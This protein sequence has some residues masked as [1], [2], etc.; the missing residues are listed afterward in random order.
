MQG[1]KDLSNILRKGIEEFT[2][3]AAVEEVGVVV[4]STDGII[5]IKG[6]SQAMAGEIIEFPNN[7]T[8]MVFNLEREDILTVLFGPHTVVREGDLARC[9][10]RVMQVPVGDALIGR[11]VD[12]IGTPIINQKGK[13]VYCIYCAIG[14]KL[15]SVVAV[16]DI[17]EKCGAMEYTTIVS[18]S[19]RASASLQYLAPYSAC[20]MAEEFMY[21]GRDALIIYDDLTK[22]AQAY[23]MISLLLRR[24]PGREA[25]PG[26]VF[27]LHSRL[28]ERGAKLKPELGGGSLTALPIIETQLG[29]VTA[30]IPTNVI[31][32]TDGQIFLETDLFN[33][34]I[35]PAVNVGISVSRVGGA[36]QVP[37]MRKIAGRLRLDLAQYREKQAFTLFATEVDE[38]TQRQLKRGSLMVEVLKQ[39]KHVP[40][41]VEDQVTILYAAANG[42]LDNVESS[43]V[44]RF[45]SELVRFV[46][47]SDPELPP[48]LS[49]FSSGA[50]NRLKKLIAQFKETYDVAS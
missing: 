50:E 5:R 11:V 44:A 19:S 28:L 48:L 15:S 30:Y 12:A 21:S 7:F 16:H 39:D 45:E 32:I 22:H 38:E 14:Q 17:L 33:A 2:P 8:G 25:Y 37:A 42:Y 41:P 43:K 18:A 47:A 40:M 36:A 10:G 34:G 26:D 49:E 13:G 1:K 46:R 6:L 31:S 27:Y 3:G 20:A 4:E 9:T 29:D 24:P 23:R 35:R